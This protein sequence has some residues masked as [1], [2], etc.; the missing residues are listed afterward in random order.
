[1]FK[2]LCDDSCEII[3][4]K[5]FASIVIRIWLIV[6]IMNSKKHVSTDDCDTLLL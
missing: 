6:L 1:M 2:Q 3:S 4:T 5:N